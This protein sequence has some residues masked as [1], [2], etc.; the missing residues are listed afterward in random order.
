MACWSAANLLLHMNENRTVGG[1]ADLKQ[2]LVGIDPGRRYGFAR[3]IQSGT[4]AAV[5][6]AMV[7]M[8]RAETQRQVVLIR[9]DDGSEFSPGK[10]WGELKEKGW[11]R[12]VN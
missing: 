8:V 4:V 12:K 11:E 6:S 3:P 2:V 5:A 9:T 10:L 1:R 7:R